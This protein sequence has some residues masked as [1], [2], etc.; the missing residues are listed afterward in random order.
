MSEEALTPTL[1]NFD[2]IVAANTAK[3]EAKPV[4]DAPDTFENDDVSEIDPSEVEEVEEPEAPDEDDAGVEE[5]DEAEYDN[6]PLKEPVAAAERAPFKAFRQALREKRVT[7]ELM[8]ALGDLELEI[9]TVNGPAKL[10][11][12]E[13]GGHVMREAR[14][15]REMAKTKEVQAKAQQII[16]LEQARSNA[17]RTNPAE[18]EH[19]LEVMGCREAAERVFMKWAREKYDYLNAS[20]ERRQ[21]IDA[22]RQLQ[23]Q[24]NIEQMQLAQA[25]RELQQLQ[26][27]AAPQFD[28]PTR[29][30]G[31]YIQKNMDG[32]LGAALKQHNAGRINDDLR[33][34]LVNEMTEL[35]QE[36]YPIELAMKEAARTVA[37]KQGRMVR[38]AG[39]TK[40]P[41]AAPVKEVSG[42]RAPA[43]N[44]PP[45]RAA[46]GRFQPPTRTSNGKR[47][48]PPT[49]ASFGERF[50]V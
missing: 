23:R 33:L 14:F 36:G 48:E 7:P 40:K 29:Q 5:D 39:T 21:E 45:K 19:G 38:V 43:G 11:L 50:G 18:L 9:E 22:V 44:A 30:A 49:A 31:E 27:Q 8:N 28:E 3:A 35:A 10:R 4:D 46:D 24:R 47:K 32:V 26:Q 17:W 15:S 13:M 42:R 16:Q 20:P 2:A 25:R 37:E 34:A 6:D 1:S 12:S 41:A